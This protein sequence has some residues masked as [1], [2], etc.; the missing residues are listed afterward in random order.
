MEHP[1]S[2]FRSKPTIIPYAIIKIELNKY[3]MYL[4]PSPHFSSDSVASGT[5]VGKI[6]VRTVFV[7]RRC[8]EAHRGRQK[9]ADL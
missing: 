3:L 9:R 7:G 6:R 1:A 5:R 2:L 8:T 4:I